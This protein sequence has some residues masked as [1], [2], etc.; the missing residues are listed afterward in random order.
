MSMN[1][2]KQLQKNILTKYIVALGILALF[3]TIAFYILH[4]S[5]KEYNNMGYVINLS[6]NQKTLTQQITLDVLKL[7]S[8]NANVAKVK[9]KLKRHIQEMSDANL[10]LSSGKLSGERE[11]LLSTAIFKIYFGEI[12]I[13]NRVI[14]YLHVAKQIL[15]F[16]NDF[17]VQGLIDEIEIESEELLLDLD[18]IVKQHELEGERK[19]QNLQQLEAIAW[20]LTVLTILL[21]ISFIF[22]PIVKKIV[23]LNKN[24]FIK[25]DQLKNNLHTNSIQLDTVNSKL[26][27][28]D[29]TDPLT[30]L[31]NKIYLEEDINTALQMYQKHNAPYAILMMNV[32][33]LKK[34]NDSF[35]N[36]VGDKV[37]Q[38]ISEI[39]KSSVREEDKLYRVDGKE[40]LVL[41]KR[42]DYDDS[43]IFAEKIRQV[44]ER[45]VFA[46]SNQEFRKTLSC[47]L[48]HSSIMEIK[49][50]QSV[51][52]LVTIALNTSKTH[53]KNRVTNVSHTGKRHL[54]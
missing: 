18:K 38:E 44:I 28:L 16:P 40:F 22:L 52:K 5:L 36:A 54:A 51:L 12:N 53:G 27:K 30:G 13:K 1:N 20:L 14:A 6:A 10:M 11:V 8:K 23:E 49:N 7:K 25:I 41:L 26:K 2:I 45:H 24:N 47:G 37:I 15:E 29:S 17:N 32:D 21:E 4:I 43:V 35:G 50:V 48:Y 19:L 3:A 46:H 33:D 9:E 42:I 39:L 31:R 34:V